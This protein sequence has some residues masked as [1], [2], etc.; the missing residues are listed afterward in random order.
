ME[1]NIHDSKAVS[2]S[3]IKVEPTSRIFIGYKKL[4]L[5]LI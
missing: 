5:Y 4:I 2:L 1:R 3:K